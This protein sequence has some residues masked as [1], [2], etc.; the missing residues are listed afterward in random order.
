SA[1]FGAAWEIGAR[2][3]LLKSMQVRAGNWVA[4]VEVHAADVTRSSE[5]ADSAI[6]IAIA[7]IQCVIPPGEDDDARGMCRLTGRTLPPWRGSISVAGD[8][9]EI[10][11]KQALGMWIPGNTLENIITQGKQVLN[12][13][14]DRIL[15]YVTGV[16]LL[17]QL[18]QAWCD[19]AFWFHEALSE[20]LDAVAVP[21]LGISM[22]VLLG[23]DSFRGSRNRSLTAVKAFFNLDSD[24]PITPTAVMN[25]RQFI[26]YVL[27]P[28][29]R[30][31]HGNWSTLETPIFGSR[32]DLT[33]FCKRLLIVYARRLTKFREDPNATDGIGPFLEWAIK[34]TDHQA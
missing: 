20:P 5:I 21:K 8:K 10:G 16:S 27:E 2:D 1:N 33:M 22:E 19:S 32:S 29:A 14:G 7:A 17:P 25:V 30:I 23:S 4:V 28:T 13:M 24:Q 26:D 11:M 34:R 12:A 6:D 3:A 31:R 18:E 9:C 15:A